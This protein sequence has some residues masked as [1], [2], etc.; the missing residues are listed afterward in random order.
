[1]R[2]KHDETL[3]KER[4]GRWLYIVCVY[5]LQ[6]KQNYVSKPRLTNKHYKNRVSR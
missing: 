1:M 5:N 4:G 2:K 3:K 6:K